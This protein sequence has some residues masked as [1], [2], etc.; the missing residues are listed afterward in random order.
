M[1]TP[2]KS[3]IDR[4]RKAV[5]ADIED[6][7]KD[8]YPETAAEK[9]DYAEYIAVQSMTRLAPAIQ[10]LSRFNRLCVAGR[11]DLPKII[12]YNEARVARERLKS[13][14]DDIDEAM[15]MMEQVMDENYVEETAVDE[16]A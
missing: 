10:R 4:L 15:D 12:M 9:V 13:V 8:N 5:F 14:L 7:D 2:S 6:G 1:S 3:E 11:G 16:R